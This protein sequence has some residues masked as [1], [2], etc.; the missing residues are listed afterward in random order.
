RDPPSHPLLRNCTPRP[1]VL[2]PPLMPY[3]QDIARDLDRYEGQEVEIR[4]WLYNKRSSKKVHFLEVRDGSGILQCV[5]GT[6]DVS[7]D[8]FAVT[9][10]LPQETSLVVY[11]KVRRDAHSPFGF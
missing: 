8:L 10:K 3:I 6:N 11:A 2:K 4:G 7:P 9:D 1:P 5:V